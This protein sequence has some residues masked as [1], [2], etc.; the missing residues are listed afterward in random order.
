MKTKRLF[1]AI[2]LGLGLALALSKLL[3]VG[4]ALAAT[5]TVTKLTDTNDGS[6]DVGDCSLREAI[7]AANANGQANT[8]TLGPGAHVLTRIG[9]DEDAADTGDLDITETLTIVGAGPT[10]T[11]IDANNIDRIFDI[12][13][14]AGTVV[15]SGVT[16]ING[17][18]AGPGGGICNADANLTLVNTVI[19]NSIAT[20]SF[21]GGVFTWSGNVTLNKGQ[22]ISN[23]ALSGGGMMVYEGKA[24]V[25][26]GQILGNSAIDQ[27]GGI[28]VW[29]YSAT[30]TVNGGRI[31]GNSADEGGG[32]FINQGSV[33]VS[34]GLIIGNSANEEGGGVFIN[35]GNVTVSEGLILGVTVSRTGKLR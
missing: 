2:I 16:V 11:I 29:A 10:Q 1:G 19:S 27:G 32:V 22:I 4:P 28:H 17:N 25:N 5:F 12:R 15:I 23:S 3:H 31:E 13:P 6:C 8:I 34:E 20:G 24:T 9:I 33:I 26:G 14:G 18:V 7:V 21:G 35:Q 30:L